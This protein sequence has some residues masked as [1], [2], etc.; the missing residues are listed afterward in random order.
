MKLRKGLRLIKARS[1]LEVFGIT[2]GS[3]VHANKNSRLS[4]TTC[5]FVALITDLWVRYLIDRRESNEFVPLFRREFDFCFGDLVFLLCF[6]F[7]FFF[8]FVIG[9]NGSKQ[10][11]MVHEIY[12][13]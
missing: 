11:E 12:H 8:F 4:R 9:T 3:S 1:F 7:F 5:P 6:V 10:F 13:T 2:D